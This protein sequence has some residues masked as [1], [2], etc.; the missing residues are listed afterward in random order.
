MACVSLP[1]CGLG[2]AESERYLPSF[3]T[4]LERVLDAAGLGGQEISIRMTG[5]PNGCARPY[6]AEI[7]LVGK[8]PGKYNILLGGNATGTRLNRLYKENV[9]DS[10]LAA[11]LAPLLNRYAR[12]R[13][14]GERFGDWCARVIWPE[15]NAAPW[16][17]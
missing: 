6:L 4:E 14:E 17:S 8:A 7:G 5:C 1:T 15:T 12:E 10:D 16:K 2:L 9:K 13:V 11:E 3:M